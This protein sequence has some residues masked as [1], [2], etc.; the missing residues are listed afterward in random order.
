MECKEVCESEPVTRQKCKAGKSTTTPLTRGELSLEC[1]HVRALIPV[2][3]IF[4]APNILSG[5]HFTTI[6]EA[7][8]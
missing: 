1:F 2:P 6:K 8:S 3:I 7:F 5:R 4:R